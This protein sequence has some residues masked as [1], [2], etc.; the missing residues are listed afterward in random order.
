LFLWQH[1]ARLTPLRRP[2]ILQNKHFGLRAAPY[3]SYETVP[4]N[5]RLWLHAVLRAA[6]LCS[7]NFRNATHLSSRQISEHRTHEGKGITFGRSAGKHKPNDTA[8]CPRRLESSNRLPLYV[9][10]PLVVLCSKFLILHI[11]KVQQNSSYPD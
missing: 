8:S 1:L 7:W 6:A 11:F 5:V 4:R 9:I 3:R 2:A 10:T